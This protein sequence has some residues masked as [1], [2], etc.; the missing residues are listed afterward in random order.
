MIGQ[1]ALGNT[2]NVA[3]ASYKNGYTGGVFQNMKVFVSGNLTAEAA[4]NLATT[5]TANDTVTINSVVFTFVAS[6][7]VAGQVAL[8]ANAAAARANL[9]AAINGTG[10]PGTGTYAAVAEKTRN[11]KLR[12][13]TA[14]EVGTTVLLTSKRGYKPLSS[15][16]AAAADKFGAVTINNIAMEQGAIHL[17]MRNEVMLKVEDIQKQL[18]K[19]FITHTRY[20]I[21]TFSE[22]AERMYN[23]KVISQAAE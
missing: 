15:N 8:G 16:L 3:D 11:N 23:I 22:G 14:S 18:G 5:P 7:T 20:G 4:L 9:I 6:A 12:G 17:V 19:R 21:K 1:G 2:F 10:T 13:L